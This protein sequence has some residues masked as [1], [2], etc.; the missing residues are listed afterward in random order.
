MTISSLSKR[1]RTSGSSRGTGSPQKSSGPVIFINDIIEDDE[2]ASR[3]GGRSPRAGVPVSTTRQ[4]ILQETRKILFTED[5]MLYPS[6]IYA[7]LSSKAAESIVI[8]GDCSDR[9]VL[10]TFSSTFISSPVDTPNSLNFLAVTST[11]VSREP[12]ALL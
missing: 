5:F 1:S 12:T 2:G 11:L 10:S 7:L 3:I 4:N 6:L 8:S 9:D